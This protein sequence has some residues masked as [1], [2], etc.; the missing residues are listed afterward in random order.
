[1]QAFNICLSALKVTIFVR[2]FIPLYCDPEGDKSH[3][4]AV[5][6]LTKQL[7][8]QVSKKELCQ[9]LEH[10]LAR[11]GQYYPSH[12]HDVSSYFIFCAK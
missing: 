11:R 1:M 3:L 9:I 2:L 4:L 5:K 10:I 7:W 6:V 8:Q 12:I